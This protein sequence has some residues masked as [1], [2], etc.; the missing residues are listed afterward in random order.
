MATFCY[1]NPENDR[2]YERNFPCGEAPE[3]VEVDGVVCERSIAAEAA[4]Q[5]GLQTSTWPM[6]SN[7]LAVHPTQR[8]EYSRFSVKHGVPTEFDVM[9]RPVFRTK[10]H[11]REYCDLVGA[12]D[13]DGGYGDP[14][15]K[16]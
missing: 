12:T 11:R 6:R 2:I 8:E 10:K 14:V 7:A 4:G 3:T 13:F 16:G 15:R 9:G 5:G 1:R